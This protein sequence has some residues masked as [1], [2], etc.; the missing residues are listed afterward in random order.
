MTETPPPLFDQDLLNR[1]LT[2]ADE[3]VHRFLGQRLAGEVIERTAPVLRSFAHTLITGPLA[4]GARPA[5]EVAERFGALHVKAGPGDLFNCVI[6]LLELQSA[7]DPVGV[8]IQHR[9]RLKPDGLLIACLFG[10][11]SLSELRSAWLAA[12]SELTGGVTPRVAPMAALRDA[13]GLLQR[14]GFA[15]PVADQDRTVLRYADPLALMREVKA[16]G[17]SNMLHGRSRRPV[18]RGLLLRAAAAYQAT[19]GD[20][21]G[22]VRATAELI[23]LTAWAPHES[24][25]QPLKPGSAKM[26]LADALK[27]PRQT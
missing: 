3:N 26:R 1:R 2:R 5:L 10:G 24:Q 17:F 25:Q 6:S 11:A 21:D 16:L 22:R 15:L 12:E 13:G 7:D 23:W 8:L 18:T 19:A 27:V 4:A 20:A 14:A 9:R